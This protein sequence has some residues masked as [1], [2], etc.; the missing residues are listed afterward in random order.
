VDPRRTPEWVG[1]RDRPNQ[2]AYLR[3]HRRSSDPSATFPRPKQ[4]DASTRPRDD[5]FRFDDDECGSPRGPR[6]RQPRPETPICRRQLQ[7]AAVSTDSAPEA[8]AARRATHAA[9][10]RATEASF[11]TRPPARPGRN[12]SARSVSRKDAN[13]NGRN[14]YGIFSKHRSLCSKEFLSPGSAR[15]KQARSAHRKRP[16]ACSRCGLRSFTS[17]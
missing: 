16:P 6:A 1:F 14:T 7:P 2:R 10:Q 5:G 12:S 17:D 3:R 15:W 9:V 13:I 4:A 8:G 11:R